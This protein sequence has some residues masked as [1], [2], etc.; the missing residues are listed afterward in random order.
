MVRTM[1][2]IARVSSDSVVAAALSDDN[3]RLYE[4]QKPLV[5]PMLRLCRIFNTV[6]DVMFYD[7]NVLTAALAAK[8][9]TIEI[10]LPNLVS[11]APPLDALDLTALTNPSGSVIV[12]DAS[13]A[14]YVGNPFTDMQEFFEHANGPDGAT[15]HTLAVTGVGSS[16][17]GAVAFAW[18]VS[19][20]LGEPVVAIVP[21]YGVA[22]VVP[23]ALGGWF[24]FEMYDAIQSA[25]QDML[26]HFSPSLATIGKTLALSTP[27]RLPATTG[28]PVFRKGSA[29][30]DDVHA[31]LEHVPRI[32]RLVGH[33]KGALAIE[34]ALRSLSPQRQARPLDI[35]TFGCVVSTQFA[36]GRYFQSLGRFDALGWL[37]SSGHTPDA[38]PAATHTTNTTN[39][40]SMK[41]SR[42]VGDLAAT[43]LI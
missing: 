26:A 41:V 27:D 25:T 11:A 18:N 35:V 32:T 40:L 42:T 16:A 1:A 2:D 4:L 8:G 15:L 39:A 29:A 19:V 20:A 30:S 22:D 33:S 37:N 14:P 24:G 23:Q 31:I 13:L 34:N 12:V 5:E 28:A 43:S 21:G 7:V 38:R 3:L 10:G 6:L 17:Y 36:R 9:R